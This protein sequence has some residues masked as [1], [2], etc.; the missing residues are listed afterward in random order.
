MSGHDHHSRSRRG[1]WSSRLGFIMASAGSAVGLG[2]IWKFPYITGMH[3]G[4][5]FVL[6]FIFCIVTV[7]IP[8]MIAEMV[9]G[10]HTRK[11]PVG[12]FR[13]ARG[14]V[15][16]G[17]GW[18][19]VIAGF[20]ILSY[21]CV[22]AGWTLDYLWLSLSGT[23]SGRH[24]ARVPELFSGL[25]ANDA[26]QVFWQ[27]LFMGLTVCIVLGGVSKGLERANKVMMPI[28]FL[29]LFTLAGYGIFSPGGAAAFRFLFHADWSRLDPPSMLE[30]MGHA[31]FSLSLG[32]GAMLTYGSYADE[33]TN[34][35]S[36]AI[37][38][39]VMDTCV[40]LLSGLAIFPIVFT[41]GMQPAAGPGLVFKTLPII[42][43]QMPGGTLIAI[44]FFLLLV[45]AA[46]TSAISLLEVV[47]AYYCDEKKWDRKKATLVMGFIIFLIGVPSALSNNL[48]KDLHFIGDRNFLDSVDLLCT[49]YILPLGGLLIA[50]FTGWVLTTR[51]ARGEV[52]KGEVR[53]RLYPVWHFL[54]RYVS[55]VLVALVFLNKIGLF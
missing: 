25:L 30:A 16:T 39:S 45:F 41:Y 29:I 17:V 46:L 48:L 54:I 33:K 53:F 50:I 19:G 22:V 26:A 14:G 31:F 43:S 9:I 4:G 35:P 38:V 32:M 21:Y 34:I 36:V 28:L 11:D 55:P 12:A 51:L 40:A 27:A 42:F 6:F 5:A 8:I 23:F 52:E 37:T 1:L 24:A 47:V 15:W 44:L 2:N 10:R 7:G 13:S 20:V 49:N 3:G 18:L